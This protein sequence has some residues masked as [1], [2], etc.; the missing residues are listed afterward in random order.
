MPR[1]YPDSAPALL[2]SVAVLQLK[3]LLDALRDLILSPVALVAALADLLLLKWQ[4][5]QFFRWVLRTG[6]FSDHWIDLWSEAAESVEPHENVDALLDRLEQV[7]RDPK[8]G[9]RK[10]RILK[11]WTERQLAQARKQAG[12]QLSARLTSPSNDNDSTQQK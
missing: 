10:A 12:A 4:R 2:K 7:V 11:R 3:L 8:T 9:A 5:P 1:Q 6:A